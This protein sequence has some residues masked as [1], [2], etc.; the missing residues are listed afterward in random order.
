MYGK[1]DATK[2]EV[3]KEYELAHADEII[4]KFPYGYETLV[5][6]RGVKLSGGHK[7]RVAIARAMLKKSQILILDEATSALDSKSEKLITNALDT[8][9][10]KRTTIVIAHRL[11][12]IKKMDR[13]VVLTDEGVV[14]DGTHSD[15]LKQ[16]GLYSELW[17]HQHDDFL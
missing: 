17:H 5:G 4:N 11:S 10:E 9:M 1:P 14:E 3:I 7:Q 15:L 12:T 13:I 6:E 2:E 8:L 16:K